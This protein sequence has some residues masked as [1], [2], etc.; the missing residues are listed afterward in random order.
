VNK[1]EEYKDISQ[2]MRTYSNLRFAQLTLFV[3]MTA[4]MLNVLFNGSGPPLTETSTLI[5]KFGGLLVAAV[6][7]VMEER[8][9]DFWHHFKKRAIKL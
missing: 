4:V 2:N 1:I 6:F 3:A 9:A 5:I 7:W 8:S